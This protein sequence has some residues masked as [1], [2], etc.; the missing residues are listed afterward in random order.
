[1]LLH[2]WLINQRGN[3]VE[4]NI[5]KN[6]TKNIS[7]HLYVVLCEYKELIKKTRHDPSLQSTR[8]FRL[9][10]T[11]ETF[12]IFLIA[13]SSVEF[14]LQEWFMLYKIHQKSY[15]DNM[16]LQSQPHSFASKEK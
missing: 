3:S 6:K 5:K 7:L 15:F 16:Q 8:I 2:P 4:D 13:E 9:V 1:M 11:N 10:Y 14:V 12:L